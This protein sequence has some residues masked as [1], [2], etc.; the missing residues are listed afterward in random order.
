MFRFQALKASTGSTAKTRGQPA[1]PHHERHR[2]Q[3]DAFVGERVLGA[4]A[5]GGA[6]DK[7]EGE[8]DNVVGTVVEKHAGSGSSTSSFIR[9]SN[10][11]LA[12]FAF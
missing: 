9:S 2:E 4:R 11:T 5:S 1:P 6:C 12:F 8:H 7:E 3:E 10:E